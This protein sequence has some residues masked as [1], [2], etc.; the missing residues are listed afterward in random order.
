MEEEIEIETEEKGTNSPPKKIKHF[1]IP[2]GGITGLVAYGALRETNISGFWNINDIESIYATSAGAIIAVMIALKYEWKIIDDYLIKRPWH[3]ICK[4]NMYAIIESFHKRGI[5]DK[6]VIV[7]IFSPLFNGLDIPLDITLLDFFKLNNI[8]LHV[9]TSE[10]NSFEKV[11][12]SYKTH[13]D[14]TV[15][16]AV[17]ASACLPIFFSPFEKEGKYY[18]DGGFFLNYPLKPCL[19]NGANEDEILSVCKRDVK[20]LQD[21]LTEEST[22]FDYILIILN[23][24]LQNI[25]MLSENET[26]IENEIVVKCPL[27]SIYDLYVMVSSAETRTKWIDE[28]VSFAKTFLQSGLIQHGRNELG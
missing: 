28:G 7:E 1:I 25:I 20:Q 10:L 3:T 26:H 11:D 4:F 17:Y 16:D 12:V 23:K 19:Q 18:V 9:Y 5:F 13:P 15:I 27:V 14:W 22:L 21:N 2:G 8:E 24:T 6:K